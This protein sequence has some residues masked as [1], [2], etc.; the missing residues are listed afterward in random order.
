MAFALYG[1]LT[2]LLWR[3]ISSRLGRTILIIVS[4]LMILAIGISLI[5]LGV[6]Y[7]S[8]VLAGYFISTFWLTLAIGFYTRRIRELIFISSRHFYPILTLL[9]FMYLPINP[10]NVNDYY[11]N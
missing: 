3:H 1:I 10:N 9:C 8:D 7:P 2:F 11:N 5:Y 6:H 4:I